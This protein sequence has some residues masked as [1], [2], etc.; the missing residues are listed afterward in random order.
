MLLDSQ[1]A[2]LRA[3]GEEVVVARARN[4]AGLGDQLRT[5]PLSVWNPGSA[6][7]LTKLVER[8]KPDVA[9]L[10]N[11]WYRWSPSI[12]GALRNRGVPVVMTV[13][14]YRMI[15]SNA[16]FYRDGRP[17]TDCLG[18]HPWRAVLH[19]CYHDSMLQSFVAAGTIAVNR[20]MGTWETGVDRFAVSTQFLRRLL[21]T[22]GFPEDRIRVLPPGIP[23]LGTRSRPASASNQ[24]VFA[25][26]IEEQKGLEPLLEAWRRSGGNLELLIIG[27]GPLR[28]SLA[29]LGVPGVRFL[30]W[31]PHDRLAQT[32]LQARALV[33]PSNTYETLGLSMI[34]GL[35]AALPVVALDVGTRREVV[36]DDG[37]GWL[38]APDAS[39]GWDAALAHLAD[40]DSV[41]AAS[42]AARARYEAIFDLRVTTPGLVDLYRELA[43]AD[44]SA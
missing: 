37:A 31:L 43:E 13:H 32:M 41:D 18:T 6:R 28:S 36:G 14:N 23:D 2:A 3:M 29:A 25:G 33:F 17:C 5:F 7:T 42:A 12:V 1:V 8:V 27:D 4:P 38:V 10:H 30:G 20:A 35:S 19:R 9:H 39:E 26:R 16:V 22:A 40:D 11:T 24:V 44:Y 21:E 34:E 15:C